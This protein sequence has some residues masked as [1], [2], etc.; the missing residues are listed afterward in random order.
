MRMSRREEG[1]AVFRRECS[2]REERTGREKFERKLRRAT[3]ERE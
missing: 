2:E 1:G 3:R